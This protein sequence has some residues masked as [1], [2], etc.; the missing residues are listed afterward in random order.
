MNKPNLAKLLQLRLAAGFL[1]EQD[2]L[3]WWPTSFLAPASK[4]FLEPVFVT[5]HLQAQYHGVTEA[6]RRV[7][8]DHLSAGSFHLFRLPEELEQ[9]LFETIK[10]EGEFVAGWLRTASH[11]GALE[12]LQS[13]SGLTRDF[14]PEGPVLVG[15]KG[16]IL[17][18]EVLATVAGAYE[19][20]FVNGT[21]AFPYFLGER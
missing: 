3:A 20:A 6:A 19:R 4:S 18:P 21:Q 5:T 1:G 10:R 16:D 13:I 14:A 11:D 8:D 15:N 17:K 7:H 12:V 2:Q 9:V